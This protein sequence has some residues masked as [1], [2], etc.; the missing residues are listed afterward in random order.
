MDRRSNNTWIVAALA[1]AVGFLAALLILGGDDS[2]NTS[3]TVATTGTNATTVTTGTA[4]TGAATT[5]TSSTSATVTT[6]SATPATP[7]ASV[8]SCVNL[9]NQPN[10][11]GNQ[12]FLL[13]IASQ[14]AVRI[15]VGI[16]SDVPPKCLITVVGNNGDA[17]VFPEAGGTTYPYAQAP[18]KTSSSDLP[19]AQKVSNALDQSDGTLKAR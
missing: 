14:Q 5:G 7:P 11:R 9:W 15:H 19:A 10:N 12:T 13:N 4:T 17:W 6:P 3:A 1:I 8:G 16:T 18:A 2:N